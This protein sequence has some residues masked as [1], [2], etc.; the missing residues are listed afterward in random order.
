[1]GIFDTFMEARVVL[2]K[3]TFEASSPEGIKNIIAAEVLKADEKWYLDALITAVKEAA[4]EHLEY[5]NKL[6]ILK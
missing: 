3:Y 6:I 5:M 1:M 4:P 2:L